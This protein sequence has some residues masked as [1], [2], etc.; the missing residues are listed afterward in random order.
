[1]TLLAEAP[2]RIGAVTLTVNDLDRVAAFY[3]TVIGLT[4]LDA[5]RGAIRL[6]TTRG[7]LI[8][9]RHDPEA[10]RRSA[11]EA[12]LFHTAFL[13]PTRADLGAWLRFAAASR[14]PIQGASDHRVSEA[15]YLAD[16]EGN[17]IEIYADRPDAEWSLPNGMIAMAT[18]P[19]DYQALL[20]A[21]AG[22]DWAGFPAG[23]TIGHVH[24]QVGAIAPAETFYSDL[25]GFDLTARYPGGSFFG[26]GGY[27]H[28]L[29]ANIWNSRGAGP[30][31][32][33]VT[34]LHDVEILTDRVALDR[35]RSRLA[36]PPPGESALA[37]RDP[38]GLSIT[39]VAR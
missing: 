8:E 3:E 19:L 32:E 2:H 6:G 12:G 21:G 10:R 26:S 28:Q 9:L 25:L 34:G 31:A 4:R 24:L 23:G 16:P 20:E 22:H 30:R 11:R 37:L 35:V 38:W 33:P 5:E 29:A 39:L 7:V 36:S 1:M 13:L 18:D 17:G 15:I 14:V 27:H